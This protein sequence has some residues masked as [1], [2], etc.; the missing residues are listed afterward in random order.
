MRT[1]LYRL[2]MVASLLLSITALDNTTTAGV[3]NSPAN[4]IQNYNPASEFDSWSRD[5]AAIAAS[6]WAVASRL[7]DSP[8]A[9][10]PEM[11]WPWGRLR[12]QPLL[13][14]SLENQFRLGQQRATLRLPNGR[15]SM[16]L[17][18]TLG[19]TR[20]ERHR[21]VQSQAISCLTTNLL[22]HSMQRI[23][24][25]NCILSASTAVA[26]KDWKSLEDLEF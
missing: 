20:A 9:L 16:K 26:I 10:R 14:S 3:F 5:P 8:R 24:L 7:W 19:A 4:A 2:A 25:N 6:V 1:F 21:P 18:A 13:V 12:I 15:K 11:L 17:A 23:C 22:R